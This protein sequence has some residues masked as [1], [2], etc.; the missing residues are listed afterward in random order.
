MAVLVA[1]LGACTPPTHP[2]APK[3][4]S[5]VPFNA[6]VESY[7]LA[8]ETNADPDLLSPAVKRVLPEDASAV[9]SG[10]YQWCKTNVSG[11]RTEAFDPV[12]GAA[13]EYLNQRQSKNGTQG[14]SIHAGTCLDE[15]N[16]PVAAYVN[17]Y[18]SNIAFYDKPQLGAFLDRYCGVGCLQKFAEQERVAR[19]R[20]EAAEAREQTRQADAKRRAEEREKDAEA[21]RSKLAVGDETHCGMVVELKTPIVKLQTP[22]GEKW[23][24]IAQVYRAGSAPC[25]FANG[26]YVEP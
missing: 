26:A 18:D 17:I 4:T 22:A 1:A 2:A 7:Q 19:E 25:N 11:G 13:A 5:G 3:A 12:S 14:L 9:E 24:K 16:D 8:V 23:L 21:F 15:G 10:F 20:S 6:F